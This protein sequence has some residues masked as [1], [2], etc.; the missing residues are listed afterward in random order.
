MTT[1]SDSCHVTFVVLLAGLTVGAWLFLGIKM[2]PL[3]KGIK[4]TGL[5]YAMKQTVFLF[6]RKN[7]S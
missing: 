5:L 6:T 4:Y 1:L 2:S 3:G 7:K